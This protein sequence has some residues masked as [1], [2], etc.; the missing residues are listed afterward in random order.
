MSEASVRE[1]IEALTLENSFDFQIGIDALFAGNQYMGGAQLGIL[2]DKDNFRLQPIKV[3]LPGGDIDAEYVVE[4]TADGV[5]ALLNIYIE[6]L[7][8]GDLVRLLDPDAQQN[9]RGFLY[10]D[11]SLTSS[12]PTTATVQCRAGRN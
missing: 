3:T 4:R 5:G 8:Y 12:A 6:R 10:L 7:Q 11:T 2:A 9:V 1:Y